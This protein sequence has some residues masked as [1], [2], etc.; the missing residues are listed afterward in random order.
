MSSS[1]KN[2]PFAPVN[3]Q[4]RAACKNLP[5]TIFFPEESHNSSPRVYAEGKR[6]CEDC[7][8]RTKCLAFAMHHERN[9]W[10]RFGLFGGKTPKERVI[11][12]TDF[13]YRDWVSE[14]MEN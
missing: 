9:Q 2:N 14:Y 10:R 5:I 8:V 1:S 11:L 12:E 6:F 13:P 3:W 4:D 7:E